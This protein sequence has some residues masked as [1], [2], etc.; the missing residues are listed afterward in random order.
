MRPASRAPAVA[1]ALLVLAVAAHA[2]TG[3]GTRAWAYAGFVAVGAAVVAGLDRLVAFTPAGLWAGTGLAVVHVLGGLVDLGGVRLYDAWVVEGVLRTDQAVH[4][5]GTVVVTHL[6]RQALRRLAAPTTGAV[7]LATVAALMACGVGA[8]NEL[9]E[10]A[11]AG[12]PGAAIGDAANTGWD[13]AFNA[14]GA[15]SVVTW[16]AVGEAAGVQKPRSAA[17]RAAARRPSP[18]TSTSAPRRPVANSTSS[19]TGPRT[20]TSAAAP[21]AGRATAPPTR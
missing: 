7:A 1:T 19:P 11:L 16:V 15:L 20:V 4:L 14:A 9:V 13:L 8:L 17:S 21:R 10:F 3:A 6:C 2:A 12:A 18:S 5:A